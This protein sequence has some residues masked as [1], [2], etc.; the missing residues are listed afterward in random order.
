MSGEKRAARAVQVNAQLYGPELAQI[1]DWR[2]AQPGIPSR[3]AAIRNFVNLGLKA[4]T[5]VPR[6]RPSDKDRVA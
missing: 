1:D 2:R 4:S 3:A 5:D 6:M